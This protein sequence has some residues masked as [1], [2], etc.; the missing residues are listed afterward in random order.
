VVEHRDLGRG[1]RRVRGRVGFE[2]T[3]A[4]VLGID[5]G[6]ATTGFGLVE[7]QPGG[8]TVLLLEYGVIRTAPPAPMP[9]RLAE[10]HSGLTAL[11]AESRPDAMAVEEL[12]FSSNVSTA[13]TVGQA[14]GVILLVAGQAGVP[15]YEYTP[16]TV[17]QAL[18]GYGGADKRQMQEM[19]RLLL[20]L[21][22]LPRPD[23]AADG[24]AVALCHLQMARIA[25]L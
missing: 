8:N 17:K 20:G 2:G 19:L 7:G 24:V 1:G 14:R 12:Y 22:E 4:R 13:L 3:T 9:E 6:T 23:D 10:I 15:V 5:P 16:G 25:D 21:E 11:V 18:T